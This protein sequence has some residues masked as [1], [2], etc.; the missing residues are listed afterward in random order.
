MTNKLEG[1][2]HKVEILLG[3]RYKYSN[4]E[5]LSLMGKAFQKT[6]TLIVDGKFYF[7]NKGGSLDEVATKYA[8]KMKEPGIFNYDLTNG[9]R[10]RFTNDERIRVLPMIKE[11]KKKFKQTLDAKLRE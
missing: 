4:G 9:E 2:T 3:V 11:D 5:H 8:I 10:C 1:E 6:Y 7:G